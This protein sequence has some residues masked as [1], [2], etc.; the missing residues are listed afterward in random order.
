MKKPSRIADEI[1][2]GLGEILAYEQ[3]KISLNTTT[4]Q[5][6]VPPKSYTAQDVRSVRDRLGCSQAFFARMIGVSTDSVRSWEQGLRKPSGAAA[7]VLDFL[8]E[9]ALLKTFIHMR[10]SSTQS[11]S[12]EPRVFRGAKSNA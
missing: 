5:V 1:A 12:A 8:N 3:G 9:P 11:R 10:S 6:P 7:R 2:Q 4:V